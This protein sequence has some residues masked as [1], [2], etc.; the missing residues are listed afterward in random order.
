[1]SSWS[2][3]VGR[4]TCF[5]GALI[6]AALLPI[7]FAPDAH[8]VQDLDV[9]FT[10]PPPIS[11]TTLLGDPLLGGDGGKGVADAAQGFARGLG[12]GGAGRPGNGRGASG[13]RPGGRGP[14]GRGGGGGGG[15]DGSG[16]GGGSGSS[17]DAREAERAKLL[18]ERKIKASDA[19]AARIRI[20]LA[21][22]GAARALRSFRAYDKK[23]QKIGGKALVKVRE[24]K[25]AI[26]RVAGVELD[27]AKRKLDSG[28]DLSKQ[29][30]VNLGALARAFRDV[31]PAL[32]KRAT[33]LYESAMKRKR[34]S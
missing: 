25:A 28:T 30:A 13:R 10:N 5:A 2:T 8:A 4:V 17:R 9:R 1:M 29:F 3:M 32:H 11:W 6:A 20:T 26:L 12:E 14:T 16:S 34:A 33:A 19:E 23:A 27:E 15:A 31:D 7:A 24:T 22:H 18:L 21:K